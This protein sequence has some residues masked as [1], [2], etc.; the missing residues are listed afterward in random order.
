MNIT[1]TN[2]TFGQTTVNNNKAIKIENGSKLKEMA[3]DIV[4]MANCDHPMLVDTYEQFV[5][6]GVK[7]PTYAQMVLKNAEYDSYY[8]SAED[9]QAGLVTQQEHL[10]RFKNTRGALA[11]LDKSF[12]GKRL[13]SA[14]ADQAIDGVTVSPTDTKAYKKALKNA[15][16]YMQKKISVLAGLAETSTQLTPCYVNKGIKK[17]TYRFMRLI[18]R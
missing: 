9:F 13:Y 14:M 6:E 2:L 7:H 12:L 11:M 1:S 4:R 15:K 18:N 3:K 10:Q 8:K 16:K 5:E 17:F